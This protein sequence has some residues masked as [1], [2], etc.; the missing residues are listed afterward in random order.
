MKLTRAKLQQ[1]IKEELGELS[2][3]GYD[4]DNPPPT[5]MIADALQDGL[6][7]LIP[8]YDAD[9]RMEQVV[10]DHLTHVAEELHELMN[11]PEISV[12]PERYHDDPGNHPE[13]LDET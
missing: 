4:Y 1:I 6:K 3:D 8:G 10:H 9:Y 12:D 13:P 7:K 5:E 11:Y 2:D